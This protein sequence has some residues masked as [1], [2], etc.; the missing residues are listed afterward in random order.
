MTCA[1]AGRGAEQQEIAVELGIAEGTV[2]NT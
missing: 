1:A 2:K